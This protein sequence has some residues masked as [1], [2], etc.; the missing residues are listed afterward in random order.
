M[1]DQTDVHDPATSAAIDEINALA[2]SMAIPVSGVAAATSGVLAAGVALGVG[3]LLSGISN[4]IPSLIIRVGDVVIENS[5]GSVERWAIDTLGTNDKPALIVG[6]TLISLL[7]GGLTGIAASKKFT[8][9]VTIFVLFGLLGGLAAGSD[10]QRPA[11]WAWF[12]AILA[13]AAGTA[14][15]YLLLKTVRALPNAAASPDQL[16][17]SRRG[18]LGAAIGAAAVSVAAPVVGTALRSRQSAQVEGDRENVAA[19]LNSIDTPSTGSATSLSA[20]SGTSL[21]SESAAVPELTSFDDIDGIA[22][23]VTPNNNFYR[24][25]SA[26]S[27]PRIDVETWSMKITGMVDQEIELTFDDLLAMDPVEE[28]VTLSCVSNNVGGDLVGNARWLGVPIKKLLDMAGVQPGA[29]QIVGRSVDGWT[30]GFPTEYLNDPDRVALVAVAMNGEPLP[31]QHGFPVRLVVA[32]LYGYV[33]AT[34][35]LK[36]I[37]LTTWDDFDG[38]WITRG[39]GKEGPIKTQ[40][41]I[42][43]PNANARLDGGGQPIAGVAWAPDRGIAKVEVL[44]T[45]VLDGEE[46]PNENWIEAEL[47]GDVTNNSWR[48]WMLPW[49]APTGD[50]VIRVRATDGQGVT[51]TAERSRVDPDGATGWHTIA[52][53]VS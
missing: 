45:E 1:T 27:V 37:E 44:I 5:P 36:E 8:A 26:L 42:D 43:V 23:L 9:G 7:L 4:K 12:S 24:I 33:S 15:L 52:V 11:G 30:G 10:P 18:F 20:G 13:A 2:P 28:F 6:I 31:T 40:S 46:E 50:H 14:T 21:E 49:S 35:W 38:Y 51:Q 53:R 47:S 32:G 41:R 29:T 17:N 16:A 34:K 19:A 3:E 48:Q 25:D 22:T 39:W